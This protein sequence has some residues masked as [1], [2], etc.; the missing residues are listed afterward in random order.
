MITPAAHSIAMSRRMPNAVA[1]I[2]PDTLHGVMSEKPES[3]DLVLD[4]LQSH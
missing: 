2:V 4:F 3:F 1:H